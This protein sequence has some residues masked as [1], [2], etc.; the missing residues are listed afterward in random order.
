MLPCPFQGKEA[1][2]EQTTVTAKGTSNRASSALAVKAL[3][4]LWI[5]KGKCRKIT[6]GS[7]W[8]H[9][10][11]L[12]TG[13]HNIYLKPWIFIVSIILEN[14]VFLQTNRDHYIHH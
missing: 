9:D 14:Q 10:S 1:D 5:L 7:L 11:V 13:V 6:G 2:K 8:T 4:L 12:H 3:L